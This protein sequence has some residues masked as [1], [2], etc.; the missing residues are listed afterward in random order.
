MKAILS[1]AFAAAAAVSMAQC[2]AGEKAPQSSDKEFLAEANRMLVAS[3]G[4][5]AC[6]QTDATKAVAKGDE[7]C[8]NAK[9]EP[10]K[11]KVYV[12]G[13]GYKYFGCKDSA[14]QGRKELLAKGARVGDV[15]KVVSKISM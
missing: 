9:K 11:F 13:V 1:L 5:K 6:C 15:Q 12:A 14:A 4:E 2:C 3:E 8:C 10:A 7:G